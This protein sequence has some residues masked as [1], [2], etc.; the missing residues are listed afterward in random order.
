MLT[1]EENARRMLIFE[2]T[3]SDR[4]AALQASVKMAAWRM[5]RMHRGLQSPQHAKQVDEARRNLED[6]MQAWRESSTYPEAAKR[7]GISVG[8]FS[9]WA[10]KEGLVPQHRVRG[11]GK[12]AGFGK[13]DRYLRAYEE[14]FSDAEAARMLG[15]P[16]AA[17]SRWRRRLALKPPSQQHAEW[18]ATRN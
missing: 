6:R 11:N 17:F 10:R 16:V 7:L 5:W 18:E 9:M 12:E 1:D 2:S 13:D 15:V 14:C 8:A 3:N 4:E